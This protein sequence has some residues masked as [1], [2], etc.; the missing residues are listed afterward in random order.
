M[1]A[2]FSI[3]LARQDSS[4]NQ[5]HRVKLTVSVTS[6]FQDPGLFRFQRMGGN[7][8]FFTGICSPADLVD[9]L[10]NT[11][12]E[13][14]WFRLATADLLYPSEEIAQDITDSILTELKTLC[15]E[16]AA[17]QANLGAQTT[18]SID[19]DG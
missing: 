8:D 14:A 5:G 6:G 17:I 18:Q 9:L 7:Q 11:P 4:S 15:Q 19:S 10:L 3:S 1:T 12:N 16:M 13:E 2:P